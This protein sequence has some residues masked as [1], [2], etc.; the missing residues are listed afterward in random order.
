MMMASYGSELA[1]KAANGGGFWQRWRQVVLWFARAASFAPPAVAFAHQ[2]SHHHRRQH[3]PLDLPPPLHTG[4]GLIHRRFHFAGQ[5]GPAPLYVG[6]KPRAGRV[7]LAEE[8]R[9][10]EEPPSPRRASPFLAE[11][12]AAE[13]RC[14]PRRRAM[15]RS[16]HIRAA[17][18]FFMD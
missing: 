3:P 2:I 16:R 11:L 13:E 17:D 14:L 4:S 10:T 5:R 15:P 6:H 12:L 7:W 8:T 9:H 1:N 18:S